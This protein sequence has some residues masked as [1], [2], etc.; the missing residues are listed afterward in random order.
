MKEKFY[1]FLDF[2][3]VLTNWKHSRE[4]EKEKGISSF[5]S[6]DEI[7]PVSVE[8]LNFLIEK[9]EENFEVQ[10]VFS[11]MKRLTSDYYDITFDMYKAGIKG[12]QL[13]GRTPVG[14]EKHRGKEIEAYVKNKNVKNF[15]IIDDEIGKIKEIYDIK[16]IIRTDL[17]DTGLTKKHVDEFLINHEQINQK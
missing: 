7:N 16:D 3:G 11:S 5:D 2:N 17:Y 8:A 6:G 10:L 1:I 12:S 9:L 13:M 14:K 4:M 15:V